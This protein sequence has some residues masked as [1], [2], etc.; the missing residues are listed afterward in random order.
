MIKE[1]GVNERHLVKIKD[2]IDNSY[3]DY[4]YVTL[5]CYGYRYSISKRSASGVTKDS[6]SII[7]RVYDELMGYALNELSIGDT[8]LILGHS[9]TAKLN[10][11]AT[12]VTIAEQ[13]YKADWEYYTDKSPIQRKDIFNDEV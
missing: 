2:I 7:V 11:F 6:Y 3:S 9:G 8:V 12:R 5:S 4:P 10:G 1:F 13:I